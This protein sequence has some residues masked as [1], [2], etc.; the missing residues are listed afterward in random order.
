MAS[1]DSQGKKAG[2]ADASGGGFSALMNLLTATEDAAANLAADTS[3]A[4]ASLAEKDGLSDEVT[5][6]G[7]AG[8]LLLPPF[9]LSLPAPVLGPVPALTSTSMSVSAAASESAS[10]QIFALFGGVAP[11]VSSTIPQELAVD[12]GATAGAGTGTPQ[13][14]VGALPQPAVALVA[15]SVKEIT[16]IPAQ[17]TSATLE[18]VSGAAVDLVGQSVK[19]IKEV[20]EIS[21]PATEPGSLPNK[22]GQPTTAVDTGVLQ[23]SVLANLASDAI[24]VRTDAGQAAADLAQASP[25]SALLAHKSAV[26]AHIA[27]AVQQDLK[28]LRAATVSQSA[29]PTADMATTLLAGGS[30]FAQPQGRFGA[31][32]GS[33]Q[34]GSGFEGAFGQAMS[35]ASRADAVFEVPPASAVVADTAVA[36]T[37]SYWAG[38][39]VQTAELTLEG[40]GD[41]PVQVSI[42]L[43]GD[44]AQIDFRTDQAGVRQVLEAAAAQ[45]KDL[46]S[47]Q[48]LQLAGVSVGTSGKGSDNGGER[49]PRPGTQQV[50]MVKTESVG[51]APARAANPAVGRSLDLFV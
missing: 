33:G 24:N 49:R 28:E 41:E 38:Q 18:Q 20:A 51:P 25:V 15:Q 21:L 13:P 31:R 34:S 37:V 43:N 10:A 7:G 47:S 1:A 19:K 2:K 12:V 9:T 17:V 6:A 3:P 44:Q 29:V 16:L 32:P 48:G 35:A 36:E 40:F 23:K 30:D 5:A 26:Q 22:A 4:D 8:A 39:G 46:L 11:L 14:L 42:S 27:S 50:T 45:L